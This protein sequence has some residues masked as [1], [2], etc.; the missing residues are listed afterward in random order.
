MRERMCEASASGSMVNN[1]HKRRL[2]KTAQV[3]EICAEARLAS[4]LSRC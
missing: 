3:P 4:Q 2:Q 1:S